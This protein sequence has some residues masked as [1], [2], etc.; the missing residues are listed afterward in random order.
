M[1]EQQ[2]TTQLSTEATDA[3]YHRAM[4]DLIVKIN[5]R[6]SDYLATATERVTR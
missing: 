1:I 5:R 6:L 4:Y 2:S 3:R